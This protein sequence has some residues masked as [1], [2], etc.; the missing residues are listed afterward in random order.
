M[1]KIVAFSVSMAML[2][3]AGAVFAETADETQQETVQTFTYEQA[4]KYMYENSLAIKAQEENIKSAEYKIKEDKVS[5][6]QLDKY[7]Y[8][9]PSDFDRYL[10]GTG[11]LEYSDTK[12]LEIAKRTMEQSKYQLKMQL[13]N[14]FYSYLN[15][16]SKVKTAEEAL[17][18]AKENER[19][20]LEKLSAGLIGKIEANSF[21]LSVVAAQNNYDEAVSNRDYLLEQ[22]K[23]V[24][25]YPSDKE[26]LVTGAFVR[27]PMNETTLNDALER[28][29]TSVSH[30]NLDT[31]IDIQRQLFQK[32]ENWYTSSLHQYHTQKYALAKAENEYSQN[33]NQLR[34]NVINSYNTMVNTYAQLD[35][36]DKAIEIKEQQTDAKK[37]SYELGLSTASEYISSV[38]ELDELKLQRTDAEIGAY[39]TSQ[40]YEMSYSPYEVPDNK[41]KK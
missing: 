39:L 19:I 10:V 13:E 41:N 38:Q 16:C 40:T 37:T 25:S 34:L 29:K 17:H 8:S 1:K 5:K 31:Q 22:L 3:S 18:N 21:S 23:D 15:S 24:M 35:Y 30:L 20:A 9:F 36:I 28:Y 27:Q 33:V 4:E 7:T 2:M 12:Q 14:S 26:L 32:Y 6:K 11:Y